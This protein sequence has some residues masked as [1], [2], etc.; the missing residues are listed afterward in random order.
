VDGLVENWLYDFRVRF[1]VARSQPGTWTTLENQKAI[2]PEPPGRP[3]VGRG[4][5]LVSFE[6]GKQVHIACVAPDTDNI[7]AL[8]LYRGN[9]SAP[10]G[11]TLIDEV[12]CSAGQDVAL[13]DLKPPSGS[14]W[15]WVRAVNGSGVMSTSVPFKNNPMRI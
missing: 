12:T 13:E 15:Y 2:D 10:A 5:L 11:A 6:M 4:Q 8:R 9:T 1:R 3:T 7:A 14:R